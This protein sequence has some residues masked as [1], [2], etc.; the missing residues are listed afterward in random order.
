MTFDQLDFT[1]YCI[2]ALSEKLNIAQPV[3]FRMLRDSDILSSYIVPSYD[4]L[5]TYGADY[6]A[7]DLVSLM[8]ER[9]VIK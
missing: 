3:I 8:R 7:D 5:H 6:I 2:G 4:V 9:G 1:T